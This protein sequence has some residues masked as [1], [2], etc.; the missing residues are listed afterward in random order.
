LG[1]KN[2]VY[3]MIEVLDDFPDFVQHGFG[4]KRANK[5][6]RARKEQLYHY[7]RHQ[8]LTPSS[9]T[10]GFT[11]EKCGRAKNLTAHHIVP[12]SEGGTNHPDNIA[13]LC[14]ACH[15][16]EHGKTINTYVGG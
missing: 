6:K 10:A 9:Y 3:E 13:V 2:V 12:L 16:A 1:W 7:R 15:L 11:C 4:K 8:G 14:I 5:K